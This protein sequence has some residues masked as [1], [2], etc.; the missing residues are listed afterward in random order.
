MLRVVFAGSPEC[1]IPSLEA[2]AQNHRIVAVVTNPPAPVGRSSQPQATPV[3]QAARRLIQ[4][5]LIDQSTPILEAPKI[6]DDLRAV[7]ASTQPD[8]MA[9]FAYGRIF[10]PKTLALFP[11]GAYNLHPSLLP[12]WRGCAPVPAAIL[13][14]DSETGISIQRMAQEMDAGDILLQTHRPLNGTE[15]AGALLTEL[16]KEGAPLFVHAINAVEAGTAVLTPQKHTDATFCSLLCKDDGQIDWTRSAAEIDARV[17]AF[18]PWP[19]AW[20]VCANQTLLLLETTW[21]ESVSQDKPDISENHRAVPGTVLG[22]DK[23]AGI[24]IQTGCGILVLRRLQWQTKKP[25][26]WQSFVNGSR[27][28]LQARLGN[29]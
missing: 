5:G 14:R 3:A 8:V 22:V 29:S 7:I 13:A 17:R 2:L 18:S 21:K 12:R 4:D 19:G 24:L 26:D 20:T 6:D 11:F 1:A 10:G 25:L 27:S 16:A 28:F 23:N 9:C 15:T